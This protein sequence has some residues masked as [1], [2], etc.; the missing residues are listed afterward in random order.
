MSR[1]TLEATIQGNLDRM[2]AGQDNVKV[3]SFRVLTVHE[4]FPK[5]NKVAF[6]PWLDPLKNMPSNNERIMEK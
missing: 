4:I 1:E 2:S 3:T 5:I 6:P